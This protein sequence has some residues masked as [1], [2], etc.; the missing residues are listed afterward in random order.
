MKT[1]FI[2]TGSPWENGYV[3][4]S[5]GK[6]NDEFLNRQIFLSLDEARWVIGRWRIDFN[7]RRPDSVLNYSTPAAFADDYIL[8]AAPALPE[9]SQ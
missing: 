2:A 3:E 1:L 8:P 7:H 6:L 4:S 5:N 9:H